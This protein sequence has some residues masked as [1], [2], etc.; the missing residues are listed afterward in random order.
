MQDHE[1]ERFDIKVFRFVIL[2]QEIKE[3]F[4]WWRMEQSGLNLV[5][6]LLYYPYF[7]DLFDKKTENM[8]D[9]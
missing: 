4:I 3:P 9:F 5:L 8:K 2:P 7:E 6:G 1:T